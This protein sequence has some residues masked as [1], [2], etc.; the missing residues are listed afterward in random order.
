MY[1]RMPY[2]YIYTLIYICSFAYIHLCYILIFYITHTCALQL[3]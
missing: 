2:M 1:L 3:G